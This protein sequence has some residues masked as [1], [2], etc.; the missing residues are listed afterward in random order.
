[1]G[2]MVNITIYV[3]WGL[4]AVLVAAFIAYG[5]KSVL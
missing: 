3:P 4:A 5:V 1:M 2:P